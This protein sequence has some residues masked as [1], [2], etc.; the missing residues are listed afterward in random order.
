MTTQDIKIEDRRSNVRFIGSSGDLGIKIFV[1][2]VLMIAW[3]RISHPCR[4]FLKWK[5]GQMCRI[6]IYIEVQNRNIHSKCNNHNNHNG[7]VSIDVV[8]ACKYACSLWFFI[9]ASLWNVTVTSAVVLPRGL[10]NF[11]AIGQFWIQFLRFR[12]SGFNIFLFPC[13][14][15]FSVW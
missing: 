5:I 12:D 11:R 2:S 3:D 8:T 10:S 15:L 9:T 13:R 6:V 14:V 4:I 1:L 7:D